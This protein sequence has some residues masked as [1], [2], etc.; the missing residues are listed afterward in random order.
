[1]GWS[2][3]PDGAPPKDDPMACFDPYQRAKIRMQYCQAR[4]G[5]ARSP[6]RYANVKSR[7]FA[8]NIGFRLV[9]EAI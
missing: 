5:A 4:D 7:A 1:M 9:R 6:E 2:A 8:P 3:P